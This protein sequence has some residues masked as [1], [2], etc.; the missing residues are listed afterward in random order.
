M[1]APAPL[2]PEVPAGEPV[3]RDRDT[4]APRPRCSLSPSRAA[5][6]AACPLLYRFRVLDGLPEPPSRAAT[7]GT[8]V[9]AV[10]DALYDLPADQRTL[11]AAQGLIGQCWAELQ[12][13]DPRLVG[14]VDPEDPRA[15]R[16]WVSAAE[17]LLAGY[18]RMED[19]SALEPASR[20][21]ALSV[22]L[23]SGLTLRGYVDRLDLAPDGA[24]RVVDYKTGRSPGP[25]DE[26]SAMFQLR[27][28]ALALYHQLGRLPRV[29][30]L[31]YLSDGVI[32]RLVPEPSD[33]K[34]T[35][36]RVEALWAAI[37]RATAS[38]DWR[39]N[40]G[41]ACDWCAHRGICPAWDGA[42]GK[43]GTIDLTEGASNG[44]GSPS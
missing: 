39:A 18:F 27:F 1:L 37:E 6:F 14:L 12:E 38:G 20:E 9:H 11:G 3:V 8:L 40:P 35:T 19:P 31:M 32:L 22:E 7:R 29:L 25:A 36:V 10:L 21:M 42:A 34:A 33:L 5:D 13:R 24:I 30:Q 41:R 17:R 43:P 23:P 15:V 4:L 26:A 28:Y 44:G 16:T 2:Q